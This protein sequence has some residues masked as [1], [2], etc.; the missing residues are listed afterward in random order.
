M[1]KW[2]KSIWVSFGNLFFKRPYLCPF[3]EV[4]KEGL[5]FSNWTTEWYCPKCETPIFNPPQAFIGVI[6]N[7]TRKFIIKG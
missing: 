4:E 1:K 6:R 2:F 7:K 5:G 3:C